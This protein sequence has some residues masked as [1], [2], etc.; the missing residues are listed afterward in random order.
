M[1]DDA[2]FKGRRL[3]HYMWDEL[4]KIAESAGPAAAQGEQQS[5][6][7]EGPSPEEVILEEDA[8]THGVVASK[9]ERLSDKKAR[10]IPVLQPPPGY[11]YAPHLQSFV[12]DEQDPGWMQA[13][14]AAEAAKA[15]TFYQK[16]Q[17]DLQAQQ[18][19]DA[20]AAQ[21][22]EQMAVQ[23]QPTQAAPPQGAVPP[24]QG[25]PPQGAPS[26]QGGV[27]LEQAQQVAQEP[28]G[29]DVA[30]GLQTP[31]GIRGEG[32]RP[33]PRRKKPSGGKGVVVRIGK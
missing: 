10:G 12:P 13:E 5:G 22:A 9:V 33:K 15:Q 28:A 24:G 25:G 27:P 32:P 11:V 1:F 17:E 2:D 20:Q 31:E 6:P 16:G 21:A 29:V 7:L 18:E 4:E 3:A 19:V 8:P 30:G 23:G 26:E 14:Q